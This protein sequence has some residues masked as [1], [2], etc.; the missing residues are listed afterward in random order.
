MRQGF[1]TTGKRHPERWQDPVGTV[2]RYMEDGCV[3]ALNVAQPFPWQRLK[4]A[5]RAC[6][7]VRR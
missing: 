3:V 2:G 1:V 4:M 5:T 6:G 7:F